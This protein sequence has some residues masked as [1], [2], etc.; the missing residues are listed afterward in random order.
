MFTWVKFEDTMLG[1]IQQPRNDTWCVIPLLCNTKTYRDRK[2][3]GGWWVL[4]R[5][6]KEEVS[7]KFGQMHKLEIEASGSFTSL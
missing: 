6:G 4:G 5:A 1:E 2:Q 3:S 7:V